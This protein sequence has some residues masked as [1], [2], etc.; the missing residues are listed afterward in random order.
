MKR[1]MAILLLLLF[2]FS[3]D[4]APKK[5]K[6]PPCAKNL[7][8]C[9]VGCTG[10]GIDSKLNQRKNIKTAPTGPAKDMT[11]AEMKALEDP[12]KDYVKNGSRAILK[13]KFGE[14][15]KIRVV[16]LALIVRPGNPES[17]NCRLPGQANQDNHIVLID[18]SDATPSL[19]DDEKNSITAEF[20]PRVRLT[21]KTLSRAV[22]KPL[23]DK[24]PNKALRV[25]VMGVLMFDSEHSFKPLANGRA[26][27][28]EIHPVFQMEYCPTGQ[29]CSDTGTSGWKKIGS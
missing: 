2:V 21:H 16:A 3:A 15:T 17:C 1:K 4:A 27:N 25:R 26:N 28:W 11:I 24:A 18:P 23:I 10:K 14:G 5:K 7:S 8:E 20:T 13:D 6:S 9:T 22:L 19:E 12:V 29:T